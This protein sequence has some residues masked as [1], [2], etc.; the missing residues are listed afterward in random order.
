MPIW[1]PDVRL[2]ISLPISKSWPFGVMEHLEGFQEWV[3]GTFRAEGGRAESG[4][5]SRPRLPPAPPRA[6]RPAHLREA[7]VPASRWHPAGISL[8]CRKFRIELGD[9]NQTLT[10]GA[11]A[12]V[13]AQI[14][15]CG[16][17]R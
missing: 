17:R 11:V 9:L 8:P 10:H 15:G 14:W 7:R 1:A 2:P 16:G 3:S 6:L 13:F 5:P 12:A 4:E